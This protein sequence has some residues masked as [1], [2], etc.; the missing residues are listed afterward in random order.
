MKRIYIAGKITGDPDY[1]EKFARL[2]AYFEG[3]GHTVLN[4][5]I[6][7]E[8]MTPLEYMSICLQMMYASDEVVFF[9]DWTDSKGAQ[10]EHALA[11]YC[12]IPVRVVGE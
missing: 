11:E 12:G 6:L 5:A 4:P 7:P 9:P 3:I 2:A 1:R 10:I 8:G